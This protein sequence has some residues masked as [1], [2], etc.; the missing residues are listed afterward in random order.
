[1]TSPPEQI[2]GAAAAEAA[3]FM[4]DLFEIAAD[5]SASLL[6]GRCAKCGAHSFP[7][8]SICSHCGPGPDVETTKLDGHGRV[9]ASTVVSVPSPVGLKPPY[10]Y[11]YIDLDDAALR[12]FGLF[13]KAD[14]LG[15]QPGTPVQ[16]VAEPL[17]ANAAGQPLVAYKFTRTDGAAA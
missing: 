10:A 13:A 7:R 8:R 4:P 14:A 5:G 3:P 11:G 9:Y 16:L 17:Y 15:L 1:V 12:V 2:A 6:G